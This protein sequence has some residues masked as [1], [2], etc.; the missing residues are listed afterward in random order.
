[1]EPVEDLLYLLLGHPL[2]L[3][4]NEIKTILRERAFPYAKVALLDASGCTEYV[5]G[6]GVDVT[7]RKEIQVRLQISDR[8]TLEFDANV[9]K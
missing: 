1:M 6:A 7:D 3:V 2:T 9:A 5:I 8:F 4:G